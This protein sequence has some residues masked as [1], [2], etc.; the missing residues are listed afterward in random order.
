MAALCCDYH[1][2]P[3]KAG[4]PK[5]LLCAVSILWL[6]SLFLQGIKLEEQKPGPQKNKVGW[7]GEVAARWAPR[8]GQVRGRQGQQPACWG[9]LSH[10][11]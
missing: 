11:I 1:R 2:P 6:F 9:P 8:G 5:G 4:A 7:V 3:A 10:A